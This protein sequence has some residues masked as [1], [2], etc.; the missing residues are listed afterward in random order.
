M[1]L[2]LPVPLP[3]DVEVALEQPRDTGRTGAAAATFDGKW[4]QPVQRSLLTLKALQL[5]SHRRHRGCG[6]NLAAR[7]D[8]RSAQLGLSL[9]LAARRD[10]HA[11]RV[12][13]CRLHRRGQRLAAMAGA[14]H[15]GQPRP[16]PDH[17]RRG[18][19]A[20]ARRMG[21]RLA[22]GYENS[23]PVRVGN[24]AALQLQLD[25]YGELADTIAQASK[26]GLPAV[27]G[28][29]KSAESFSVIWKKSGETGRRDMGNS[30]GAAA[31]HALQGDG[32]GGVRPRL[33]RP[34]ADKKDRAHYKKLA[35][36]SMPMSASNGIDPEKNCFVQSYG[37]DRMDASLL[38]LPMVGF[39]R[40]RQAH[41]KH[42]TR[43]RE[44]P[45]VGWLVLRYETRPAWT[46]CRRAKAPFS[47]AA[48]GWSTTTSCWAAWP[49]RSP[50]ERLLKSATMSA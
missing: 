41:P 33:A 46:G 7:E 8:R 4:R 30:R 26:G 49:R 31:L 5:S 43:D 29:P 45:D 2:P 17:V 13:Q 37:S 44:A 32:L 12:P 21:D 36:R 24:A 48:S 20:S 27:R 40:R 47:P 23:T 14:L 38:L 28:A 34:A 22:P 42:G 35:D 18:G 9:L 6:H 39:L 11:A 3:L 15:R 16:D 19:R 50:A 10:L 25:I 1:S